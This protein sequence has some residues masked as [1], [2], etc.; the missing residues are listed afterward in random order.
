[1]N[2]ATTMG[3]KHFFG[4]GSN[5]QIQ[6]RKAPVEQ[7][8]RPQGTLDHVEK[9]QP[10]ETDGELKMKDKKEKETMSMFEEK[11]G[12]PNSNVEPSANATLFAAG[13][14]MRGELNSS[15]DVVIEG[16]FEGPIHSGA[17]VFVRRDGRVVGDVTAKTVSVDGGTLTGNI[18]AFERAYVSGC[19]EGNIDTR[20]LTFGSGAK[21]KGDVTT[22]Q[23]G[24][25]E[26]ASVRGRLTVNGDDD[27]K[28]TSKA[29]ADEPLSEAVIAPNG[30]GHSVTA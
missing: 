21:F 9:A 16:V 5:T 15:S 10:K 2:W 25:C 26:G 22:E 30:T 14:E 23:L 20:A 18:D 27:S 11:T 13:V 28:P 29:A 7:Q 17:N 6:P 19:M 4:G 1:M 24:I 8:G 3:I 12:K